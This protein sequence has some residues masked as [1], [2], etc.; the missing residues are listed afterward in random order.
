M[1]PVDVNRV[2]ASEG[3]KRN[4]DRK[5]QIQKRNPG[6]CCFFQKGIDQPGN[7]IMI[8]ERKQ[9]PKITDQTEG[10]PDARFRTTPRQACLVDLDTG[11]IVHHGGKPHQAQ[12]PELPGGIKVPGGQRQKNQ[13]EDPEAQ[14]HGRHQEYNHK[15]QEIGRRVEHDGRRLITSIHLSMGYPFSILRLFI[16]S[17]CPGP[18]SEEFTGD[19]LGHPVPTLHRQMGVVRVRQAGLDQAAHLPHPTPKFS[20]RTRQTRTRRRPAAEESVPCRVRHN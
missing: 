6:K 7:E 14:H 2:R 4:P 3:V 20:C 16:L 15:K 5:D 12:S 8:L 10:H 17:L 13:P 19:P 18:T 11:E 1:S 9:Q